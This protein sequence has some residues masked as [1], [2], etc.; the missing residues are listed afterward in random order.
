MRKPAF[1]ICENKGT[2]KL[3]GEAARSPHSQS[4]PLFSGL[5]EKTCLCISDQSETNLAV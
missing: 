3:F 2:D 5:Y 4:A 1:G